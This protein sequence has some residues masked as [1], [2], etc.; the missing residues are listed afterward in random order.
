MCRLEVRYLRFLREISV[1]RRVLSIYIRG[2]IWFVRDYCIFVVKYKVES[3]KSYAIND[4]SALLRNGV[5][6]G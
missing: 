2:G 5:E 1:V 6:W 3:I 4:M